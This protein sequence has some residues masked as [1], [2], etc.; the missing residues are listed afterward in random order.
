VLSYIKAFVLWFILG[1]IAAALIGLINS[2]LG[3][4]ATFGL[5][6]AIVIR[7]IVLVQD[8]LRRIIYALVIETAGSPRTAL[9]STHENTV[10]DLNQRIVGP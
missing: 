8:L 10:S 6:V 2:T 3:N 4:I 7:T 9:V 1:S 5:F